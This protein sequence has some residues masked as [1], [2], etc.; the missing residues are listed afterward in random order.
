MLNLGETGM[1]LPVQPVASRCEPY[2]QRST[3]CGWCAGHNGPLGYRA[4]HTIKRMSCTLFRVAKLIYRNKFNCL[5]RANNGE[6]FSPLV[7]YA[8]LRFQETA[9]ALLS[10][11]FVTVMS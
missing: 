2:P 11:A 8:A 9:L 7:S 10:G 5:Q 4:Y 6:M 1:W 3:P